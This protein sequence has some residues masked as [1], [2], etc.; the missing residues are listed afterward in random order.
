MVTDA[1][2]FNV[3]SF[4]IALQ[5]VSISPAPLKQDGYCCIK[6]LLK[7]ASGIVMYCECEERE[8]DTV[9]NRIKNNF[10]IGVVLVFEKSPPKVGYFPNAARGK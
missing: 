10:F 9:T 6:K 4:T 7:P 1:L 5:V 3:V 2:R 8:N